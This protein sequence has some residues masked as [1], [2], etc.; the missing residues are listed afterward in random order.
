MPDRLTA[1]AISSGVVPLWGEDAPVVERRATRPTR[2]SR[3]S[4]VTGEAFMQGLRAVR[5]HGV[6]G[7][8]DDARIALGPWGFAPEDVDCEVQLWHGAQDTTVPLRK[9]L[10]VADRLAHCHATVL[11]DEGHF[12][13]RRRM[14]EILGSLVAAGAAERARRPAA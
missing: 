11:L 9:A 3:S 14:T 5:T 13:L 8:L 1:V 12:F 10:A 7:M 6:R 4:R 2:R